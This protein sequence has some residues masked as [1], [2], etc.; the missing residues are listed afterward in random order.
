MFELKK[1]LHLKVSFHADGSHI[2]GK[3][4]PTQTHPGVSPSKYMRLCTSACS[5]QRMSLKNIWEEVRQSEGNERERRNEQEPLWLSPAVSSMTI[6][7]LHHITLTWI[8]LALSHAHFLHLD[9]SL[10]YFLRL[11][12]LLP[13]S[14]YLSLYQIKSVSV[15]PSAAP[16]AVLPR[17]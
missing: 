9:H 13:L 15:Y 4:W 10:L 8:S 17:S 16:R 5:C 11:S 2:A 6:Q 7:L 12:H 1:W 14:H 3:S